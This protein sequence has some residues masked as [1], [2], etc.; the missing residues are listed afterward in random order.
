M[1]EWVSTGLTADERWS[2]LVRTLE[3]YSDGV[4]SVVFLPDGKLIALRSDGGTSKIWDAAL[5][6]VKST[7]EGHGDA[8]D[9]VSAELC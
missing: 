9:T 7:L 1:P 6:K 5:G 2:L 4:W 8:N 3:G